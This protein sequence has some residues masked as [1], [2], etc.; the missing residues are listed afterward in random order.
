MPDFQFSLFTNAAGSIGTYNF[1]D[2]F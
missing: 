2:L 1:P